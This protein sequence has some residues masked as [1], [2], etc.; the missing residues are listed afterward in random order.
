MCDLVGF[1]LIGGFEGPGGGLNEW[2]KNRSDAIVSDRL[3]DIWLMTTLGSS[4]KI[5]RHGEAL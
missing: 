1:G 3:I 5:K 4:G 2:M